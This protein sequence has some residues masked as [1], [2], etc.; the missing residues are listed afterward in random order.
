MDIGTSLKEVKKSGLPRYYLKALLN[1]PYTQV[2]Y[3]ASR[4]SEGYYLLALLHASDMSAD[5]LTNR[6]HKAI[7][8]FVVDH[9]TVPFMSKEKKG[10]C[11]RYYLMKNKTTVYSI[12]SYYLDRAPHGVIN[13]LVIEDC[14]VSLRRPFTP[15]YYLDQLMLTKKDNVEN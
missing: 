2:L 12:S 1:N 13:I 4:H 14:R 6:T 7:K 11:H 8:P 15:G 9:S 5:S 3:S 10:V